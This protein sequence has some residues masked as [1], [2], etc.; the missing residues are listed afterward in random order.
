MQD[1][2]NLSVYFLY[3]YK[4][5]FRDFQISIK[6]QDD[7]LRIGRKMFIYTLDEQFSFSSVTPWLKL[8]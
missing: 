4:L 3:S 1:D 2:K 5:F 8:R 6:T 7:I